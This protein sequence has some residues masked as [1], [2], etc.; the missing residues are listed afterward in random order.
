MD[1]I[2][3]YERYAASYYDSTSELSMEKQLDRFIALLPENAEVLDL[4]CGSGRDTIYLE[5]NGCQVTPMDGSRQMCLLAEINTDME[6][7]HMTFDEMEFQEVFDGIW[8]CASL[9]HV[10]EEE[11]DRIMVR[12]TSALVPGGILYMSFKYGEGEEIRDHRLYHNYTEETAKEMLSHEPELELLEMWQS[13]DVR[14]NGGLW[15]NILA[16]RA[17]AEKEDD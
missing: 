1:S 17:G 3:Y 2:D 5:E 14:G 4:G 8:A 16:K 13:E 6:V 7:L 10:P 15:L 11:M 9:L 12:V